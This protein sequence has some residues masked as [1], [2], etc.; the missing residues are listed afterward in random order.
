MAPKGVRA[1]FITEGDNASA[2][3]RK[4]SH[5]QMATYRLNQHRANHTTHTK[6]YHTE[7]TVS[8]S[9]PCKD[10][11][12]CAITQVTMVLYTHTHTEGSY[13]HC[14]SSDTCTQLNTHVHTEVTELVLIFI[15]HTR[16]HT[17]CTQKRQVTYSSSRRVR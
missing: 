16:R 9:N 4:W 8:H 6:T 2:I 14:A 12:M 7:G 13:S 1:H 5:D 17:Q 10:N 15:H 11:P 3:H